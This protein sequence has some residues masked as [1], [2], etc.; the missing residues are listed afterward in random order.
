[1]PKNKLNGFAKTTTKKVKIRPKI[2]PLVKEL[3]IVFL[4]NASFLAP[5]A[6]ATEV[7]VPKVR[8]IKRPVAVTM[9]ALAEPNPA[10]GSAPKPATTQEST[11]RKS[12]GAANAPK[13]GTASEITSFLIF[14]FVTAATL[15][16]NGENIFS[17]TGQI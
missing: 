14:A 3:L 1:M 2:N 16:A 6:L 8:K 4:I 5:K 10:N 12:E 7:V 13:A 11:S 9:T 15:E 17:P